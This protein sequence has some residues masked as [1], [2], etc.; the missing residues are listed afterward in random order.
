MLKI[1]EKAPNFSLPD[2]TGN[3]VNLS[4]FIGKKVVI[5]FYPKDDTPGC[6]KQAC[7]FRDS[8]K[9]YTDND[10]VLIGI[11]KD[12]EKSHEKFTKKYDLPFILLSDTNGE[13]LSSYGVWKQ[14]SMYG[15]TFMGVNRTTYVLDENGIVIKVFEKAEPA[16]NASDILKFLNIK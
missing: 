7:A 5:Y 2:V 16:T 12:N 8:Y 4:S 11:S 1:G 9:T 13:T 14:K 3:I 15:K 6:T 10:I